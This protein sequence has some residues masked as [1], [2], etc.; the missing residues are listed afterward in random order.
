MKNKY[1]IYEFEKDKDSSVYTMR[2]VNEDELFRILQKARED[3]SMKI[4]VH[5]IGDCVIDWS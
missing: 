1:L 5:R 2:E 3:Q 4:A